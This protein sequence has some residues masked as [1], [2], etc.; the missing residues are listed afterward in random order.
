MRALRETDT[1]PELVVRKLLHAAGFRYRVNFRTE[2]VSRRTIDIAF[3]KAK[4]AVFIDGCF[5][6]GCQLHKTIPKNN[7]AWW[8]EKIGKAVQEISHQ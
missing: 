4:I 3:L 8:D 6:H 1:G 5:W 2:A 7:H